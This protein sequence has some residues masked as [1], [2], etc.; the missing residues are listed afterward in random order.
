[1][2]D[3]DSSRKGDLEGLFL[4]YAQKQ[5]YE[6][7]KERVHMKNN[8]GKKM[9][10]SVST[11]QKKENFTGYA[12]VLP[13]LLGFL[14]FQGLPFFIAMVL[15]F[16]NAR[17]ISKLE[18]VEFI[19]LSNFIRMFQDTDTMKALGR[20]GMY[21]LMYVP[22][23][24]VCGFFIAYMVNKGIHLTKV[25]RSMFFLPYVSNMVAVAVVFKLLLGPGGPVVNLL[26]KMGMEE[27]PYLLYGLNTALPTVVCIA[28]WK[29]IGL[30]FI[31]YLA[32]LQN[33]SSDLLEA[34]QI[35]GAT[36]WERIRHIII[37]SVSPTTFFLL[38]SSIITSLQNFTT[39]QALTGGGPGQATTVMSI[40]IIRTAFSNYQT[41]YASAQALVMFLIV[42]VITLIQWR[43]Q[44]KW[45]NY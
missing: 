43:G 23:I 15:G 28:V 10:V 18:E 30:N 34:A 16:T 45:V 17:Y 38:I 24:M 12:F 37:P 27:P 21:T 39:I 22:L 8:T 25:V 19:G 35:D 3:R 14:I 11:A 36:K 2:F 32:A 31:T 6:G 41:G 1:M 5:A 40:N 29:G 26:L 20:T 44:K 13:Y 42:L 33:V 9:R 7:K 4:V